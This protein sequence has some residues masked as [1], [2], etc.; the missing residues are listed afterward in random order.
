LE[1]LS[2]SSDEYGEHMPS[3]LFS[4]IAT[5]GSLLL[6]HDTEAIVAALLFA[7]NLAVL[8]AAQAVARAPMLTSRRSKIP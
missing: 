7:R 1:I 4:G 5:F 6:G 2:N 3:R 8:S